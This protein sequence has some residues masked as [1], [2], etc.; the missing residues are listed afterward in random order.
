MPLAGDV[1][2]NPTY[3]EF[4]RLPICF[5]IIGTNSCFLESIGSGMNSVAVVLRTGEVYGVRLRR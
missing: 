5:I 1:G 2:S 4:E 3:N